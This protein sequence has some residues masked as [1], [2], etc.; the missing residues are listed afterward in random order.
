[1]NILPPQM[2]RLVTLDSFIENQTAQPT[3]KKKIILGE[4]LKSSLAKRILLSR[5]YLVTYSPPTDHQATYQL[6]VSFENRC[7]HN[8]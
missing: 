8:M 4:E 5:D 7:I 1:M 2:L 3:Y 6:G